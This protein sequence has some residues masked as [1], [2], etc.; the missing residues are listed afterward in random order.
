MSGK[1]L[2]EWIEFAE[3]EGSDMSAAKHILPNIME[4]N[5]RDVE[6]KHTPGCRAANVL[7]EACTKGLFWTAGESQPRAKNTLQGRHGR[8]LKLLLASPLIAHRSNRNRNRGEMISIFAINNVIFKAKCCLGGACVEVLPYVVGED[9]VPPR[10]GSGTLV[11]IEHQ[12][13]NKFREPL[14]CKGEYSE[15]LVTTNMGCDFVM[16]R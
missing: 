16:V 14:K 8:L 12:G 3:S 13:V 6:I 10:L 2:D 5:R 4:G 9:N 11:I 15:V 7:D 1:L